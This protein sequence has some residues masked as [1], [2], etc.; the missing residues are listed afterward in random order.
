MTIVGA[1]IVGA[2]IVTRGVDRRAVWRLS[3]LL[4]LGLMLFAFVRLGAVWLVIAGAAIANASGSQ[5]DPD[6]TR[7]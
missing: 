5:R 7:T 3:G 1:A 2:A 6:A 4:G